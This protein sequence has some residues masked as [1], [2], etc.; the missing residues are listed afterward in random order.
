MNASVLW[1]TLD[2]LIVERPENDGDADQ[3]CQS[4]KY[5]PE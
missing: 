5:Q 1:L 2:E 4:A 3:N